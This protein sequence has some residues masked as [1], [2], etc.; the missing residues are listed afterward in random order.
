M[1][2][3][4]HSA[5]NS[6]LANDLVSV[7]Q[8]Y[9]PY[10]KWFIQILTHGAGAQP[11]FVLGYPIPKYAANGKGAKLLGMVACRSRSWGL[12]PWFLSIED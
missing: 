4:P 11:S 6:F 2:K 10:H 7:C 9:L 12:A 5:Q 1:A 3:E 8:I